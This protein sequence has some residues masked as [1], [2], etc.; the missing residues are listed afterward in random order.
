[1]KKLR[2]TFEPLPA[3]VMNKRLVL[4]AGEQ[5]LC[6]RTLQ[7][8]IVGDKLVASEVQNDWTRDAE[9]GGHGGCTE[10]A[11][12]NQPP[13]DTRLTNITATYSNALIPSP[14]CDFMGRPEWRNG[15]SD[16]FG[17]WLGVAHILVT[18]SPS[19][20]AV[21]M[22]LDI[23]VSS[24]V[25]ELD[26]LRVGWLEINRKVEKMI[27]MTRIFLRLTRALESKPKNS[28]RIS[29]FTGELFTAIGRL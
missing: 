15:E 24:N 10:N 23:G 17:G 25:D 5:E 27:K 4:I 14:L 7:C 29:R 28:G 11:F 18:C 9:D 2:F 3:P 12:W 19:L 16:W 1:M 22:S 20:K 8:Q 6:M 21:S 13:V 26:A